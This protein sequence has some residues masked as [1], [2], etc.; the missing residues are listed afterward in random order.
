M[1]TL[2]PN[3]LE[4]QRHCNSCGERSA[5]NTLA[6]LRARALCHIIKKP[7]NISA[8]LDI[9]CR[10]GYSL[11]EFSTFFHNA[12][13]VGV[14]IVQEFIDEAEG[15]ADELYCMDCHDL[16]RFKDGEFDLVFTSHTLEHCYDVTRAIAEMKR[17]AKTMMCVIVPL[18]LED[19]DNQ[20][21]YLH[22]TQPHTW[23]NMIVDDDWN[24]VKLQVTNHGDVEMLFLKDVVYGTHAE[25]N[26]CCPNIST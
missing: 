8:I 21:H 23:I 7:D 2:P 25:G 14:D 3:Y 26:K 13:V 10:K 1:T 6:M 9:G 17:V 12:R 16:S 19:E 20:S 15:T 5:Y 11:N 22:I 18:E 24:I 4:N